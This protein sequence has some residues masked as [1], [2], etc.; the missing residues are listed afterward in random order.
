M[1]GA[2]SSNRLRGRNTFTANDSAHISGFSNL[3]KMSGLHQTLISRAKSDNRNST[4]RL[5]ICDH[6]YY[7]RKKLEHV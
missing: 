4:G 1:D 2:L 5:I 6:Y 7:S 3:A